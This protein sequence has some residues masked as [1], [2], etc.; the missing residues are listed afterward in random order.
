MR[1]VIADEGVG[2]G[3]I[4][5]TCSVAPAFGNDDAAITGRDSRAGPD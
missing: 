4:R 1:V 5:Q 3:H 2:S